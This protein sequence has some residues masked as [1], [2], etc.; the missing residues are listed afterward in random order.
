MFSVLQK[1]LLGDS[2]NR[3]HNESYAEDINAYTKNV[4]E[5]RNAE[6]TS[7]HMI[8]TNAC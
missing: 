2:R 3:Q 4:S 1:S 6:R 8:N 5:A 7:Q